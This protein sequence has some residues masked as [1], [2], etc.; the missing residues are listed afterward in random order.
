M[1][2]VALAQHTVSGIVT[3]LSSQP[4]AN[5]AVSISSNIRTG[6]GS[7]IPIKAM[8]NS[9]GQYSGTLPSNLPNNTGLV[10]ETSDCN[11]SAIV[12][13]HNYSGSNITS[14]F[15][16]CTTPSPNGIVGQVYTTNT[17]RNVKAVVYRIEKCSG[18]PTTLT[19]IDSIL[20]DTTGQYLFSNYPTLS[21]GCTLLMKAALLPTDADY[22]NYLPSYHVNMSTTALQW[23]GATAITPQVAAG[24]V[25]F[26]MTA[27]TNSGGPG[28]IGGSVLQGANK[29]T[30]V[31]DPV[32]NRIFVLTD[33]ANNAIAYTYSDAYGAFSFGN[34][35]YGTYKLFGDA[36][37]KNN[38]YLSLT[39]DNSNTTINSVLFTET[40]KELKGQYMPNS[41]ADIIFSED[42]IVFPNPVNDI[43]NIKGLNS[44]EG[45]KQVTIVSVTGSVVYS[46][47]FEQQDNVIIPA[48]NM[49]AGIYLLRIVTNAGIV[50]HKIV[51]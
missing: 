46:S 48:Q 26:A 27:G 18:N 50:Q 34:L 32:P 31:G 7:F 3:D 24:S 6:P 14:N 11:S 37:G 22:S 38:P 36:W 43:F 40:S 5:H 47:A 2:G 39:I 45:N 15:S 8:T 4:I 35:P 29:G 9:Q 28:F 41:V 12:N 42:V 16:I 51:K 17:K 21:N 33:A 20:T 23:S 19:L 49:S 30:G 44:I 1:S 10:V 13:S 25:D